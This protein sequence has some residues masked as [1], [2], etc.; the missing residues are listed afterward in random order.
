[1]KFYLSYLKDF[2][3]NEYNECF[4]LMSETRKNA[5]LRHKNEKNRKSTVLGEHLARK[6]VSALL[7]VDEKDIH[8]SRDEN[9]KPFVLN[10]DVEFSISHSGEV[11]VCAVDKAK[12]GIDVE[13][14][15]PINL[16]VTKIACTEN[17]KEFV[18]SADSEE[19]KKE[20]FFKIWTAKEA[21]FKWLGTGITNLRE[22][23]Y[24]DLLP[25]CEVFREGD[26][27]ITIYKKQTV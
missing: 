3:E 9:G 26:Y 8:F 24:S 23:E 21:Y 17:E 2:S 16:R 18:F 5:V 10:H 1:M 22:V 15:R 20:R 12:I 25:F 4:A 19:E 6:A 7:N 13:M 11:V 27:I 14:I